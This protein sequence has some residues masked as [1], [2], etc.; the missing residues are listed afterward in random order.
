[1]GFAVLGCYAPGSRHVLAG[2][3][4]RADDGDGAFL[5]EREEISFVLE[6]DE[7]L[8]GYLAGHST[9]FV[10]VDARGSPLGV[11]VFVWIIE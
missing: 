10:G 5:V 11:A 6:E 9:V 7:T 3:G 2:V 4:E 8:C 1:M